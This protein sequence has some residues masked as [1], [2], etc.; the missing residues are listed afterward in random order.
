MKP[1][2]FRAVMMVEISSDV[3]I[4]GFYHYSTCVTLIL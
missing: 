2:D 3:I 1:G 4:T